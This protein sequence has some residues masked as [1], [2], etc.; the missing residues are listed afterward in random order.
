MDISF[1]ETVLARVKLEHSHNHTHA[2]NHTHDGCE[3]AH[4]HD[5]SERAASA[6]KNA[7]KVCQQRGVRLTKIRYQVLQA[8]YTTHRPLGAYDIADI[9]SRDESHD[10]K[11]Y[12]APVTI[13]RALNFLLEQGFVHRLTSRNAFVACPHGHRPEDLV[14]FLICDNCGGVDELCSSQLSATVSSL[15]DQEKF[16]PQSQVM[17]ITGL[18]AHCRNNSR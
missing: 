11:R 9:L 5:Q 10:G 16:K 6:I 2:H 13:Y 7:E 14:V 8:L 15:L 4:A 1:V 17:E 3:C 18:C 12:L